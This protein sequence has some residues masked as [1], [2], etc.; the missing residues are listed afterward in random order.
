[1]LRTLA[2]AAASGEAALCPHR[3]VLP[4]VPDVMGIDM[5]LLAEGAARPRLGPS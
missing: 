1:M 4:D 5:T 2:P 3:C